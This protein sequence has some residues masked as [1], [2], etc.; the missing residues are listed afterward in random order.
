MSDSYEDYREE[1]YLD[2]LY[3]EVS[4]DA[5]EKFQADRLRSFYLANPVVAKRPFESLGEAKKLLPNHPGAAQ[6]FAM[7]SIEVGLKLVFVKPI[8]Y[9]LVHTESV[10][11]LVAEIVMKSPS[12]DHFKNLIWAILEENCR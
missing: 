11:D 1:E 2:E 6:I 10:A 12:L 9:G 8:V 5:I 4:A 3:Q 7:T